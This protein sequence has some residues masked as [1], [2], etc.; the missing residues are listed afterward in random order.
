M[1]LVLEVVTRPGTYGK[2]L[3]DTGGGVDGRVSSLG[4]DADGG[5]EGNEE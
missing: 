5:E 2:A 1:Y 4:E 3:G